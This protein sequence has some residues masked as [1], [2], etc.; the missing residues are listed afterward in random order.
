[1]GNSTGK[2]D[3]QLFILV[4]VS[5]TGKS[6]LCALLEKKGIGTRSVSHTTRNRRAGETEGRD[7]FFVSR[8]KFEKMLDEGELLEHAKVHGHF[9]GTSSKWLDD[10]LAQGKVVLLDIDIQGARQ[11]K[12]SH[13]G[14]KVIFI[15]PPDLATVE[16]RLKE[17]D[18]E[19]ASEIKRR[20]RHGLSELTTTGEF[21][22]LLVNDELESSCQL[23]EQIVFDCTGG[24]EREGKSARLL[25][26]N[27][28][29][30]ARKW[31]D[32]AKSELK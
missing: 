8:E 12:Q 19:D 24:K 11:I 32:F 15:L 18:R 29:E 2:R 4:G 10:A 6:T 7:Y 13:P 31:M 20:L 23:I 28:A 3:K 5:G 27:Q 21:D 26:S 30:L 1:M 16:D 14:C 9:Y 25:T 22:Y 17:R